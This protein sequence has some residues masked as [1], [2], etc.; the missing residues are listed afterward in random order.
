M[1]GFKALP[2]PILTSSFGFPLADTETVNSLL[3]NLR[4]AQSPA[5]PPTHTHP[6]PHLLVGG[7]RD[8][9]NLRN[10]TQRAQCLAAEAKC[11]QVLRIERSGGECGW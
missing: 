8:D 2:G 10:R 3:L 4:M 5:P 7:A 9:S 11:V 1:G 6:R